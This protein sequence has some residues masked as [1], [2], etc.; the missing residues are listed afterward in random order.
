MERTTNLLQ[1]GFRP[2]ANMN[3]KYFQLI[4]Q[5]GGLSLTLNGFPETFPQ[6]LVLHNE[7]GKYGL[8]LQSRRCIMLPLSIVMIIR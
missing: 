7:N 8:L 6:V 5:D 1:K 4:K 3:G 2:I